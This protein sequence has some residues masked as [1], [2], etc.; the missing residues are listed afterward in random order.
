MQRLL[1][2]KIPIIV[3]MLHAIFVGKSFHV[4]F[5]LTANIRMLERIYVRCAPECN[6]G[7]IIRW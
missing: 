2:C 1:I 3:Q 4:A 6:V 5:T 7:G